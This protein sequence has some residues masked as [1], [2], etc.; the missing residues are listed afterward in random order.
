MLHINIFS[1]TA[2][3][4]SWCMGR[5]SGSLDKLNFGK[6]FFFLSPISLCSAAVPWRPEA[7]ANGSDEVPVHSSHRRCHLSKH[8]S[9]K[10]GD[11]H[12]GRSASGSSTS[13]VKTTRHEHPDA[14]GFLKGTVPGIL[15]DRGATVRYKRSYKMNVLSGA[16]M[17][18]CYCYCY[19]LR[20]CL[21][22]QRTTYFI[23]AVLS[24]SDSFP[25][26]I[27]HFHNGQSGY[28]TRN[29]EQ[30]ILLLKFPCD[31]LF[32]PTHFSSH[33]SEIYKNVT[34]SPLSFS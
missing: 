9:T 13:Q 6:H 25:L 3:N 32:S 34:F 27:T 33:F 5:F 18:M 7:N 4:V 20:F 30:Q 24:Q 31:F 10:N 21:F 11:P 28:S 29:F 2:V 17:S 16:H 15:C 26:V 12:G 14:I 1:L 8:G 19:F 23:T 22:Y